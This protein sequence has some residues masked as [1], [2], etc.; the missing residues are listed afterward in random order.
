MRAT[1]QK[2]PEPAS[3]GFGST[4]AVILLSALVILSLTTGCASKNTSKK[5]DGYFQEGVA[6]LGTD[7]QR[8]FV[9]FQKAVQENPR[10][11]DAHYLLAH[12]YAKQGKFKE[13]EQELRTVLDIAPEYSEAHTYL[14]QILAHMG[15]WRE[16]M[17][18]YRAAL[19]NPLYGTPDL[20]RF[21]LGRALAQEGDMREAIRAYEDALLV[22]PPN[23]PPERVHLELGRAYY[24]LGEDEKAREA[25]IQVTELDK[26]GEYAEQAGALLSRLKH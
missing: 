5:A 14:G 23:V 26:S 12:L 19:S 24:K 3:Y 9:S 1:I 18:S 16:A 4:V 7:Q 11:R 6:Q 8:A 22:Q 10:H 20:A 17:E 25:L 13:A 21:H 15:R 2:C